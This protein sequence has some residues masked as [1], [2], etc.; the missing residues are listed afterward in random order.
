MELLALVVLV[1][2]CFGAFTKWQRKDIFKRDNATCQKCGRQWDY[3]EETGEGGYML[4]CHHKIPLNCGGDNSVS[5][6]ILVCRTCHATLHRNL[7]QTAKTIQQ[8]NANATAYRIIKARIK[9]KG[10]KRYGY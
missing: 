10:L 5:N 4:E 6:G 7:A 9:E 8:R 3:N 2:L 1:W